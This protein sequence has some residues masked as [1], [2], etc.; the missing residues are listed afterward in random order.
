M[1]YKTEGEKSV[2]WS[3]AFEIDMDA[4]SLGYK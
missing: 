2:Y 3:E 4:M 1:E